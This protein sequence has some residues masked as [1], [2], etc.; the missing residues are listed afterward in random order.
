MNLLTTAYVII[1]LGLWYMYIV[2]LLRFSRQWKDAN[3]PHQYVFLMS[4]RTIEDMLKDLPD[5]LKLY[6]KIVKGWLI[7]CAATVIFGIGLISM[8]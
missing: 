8:I 2:S 5:L 1:L 4:K 7:A 6:R 3:L